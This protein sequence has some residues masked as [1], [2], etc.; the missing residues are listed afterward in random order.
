MYTEHINALVSAWNTG[1]LG[2]LDTFVATNTIRRAPASLFSDAHSLA[3]LKKVITDFR[4]TF[5]DTRVTIDEVFFLEGRSFSKWTFTG[6]NT[7]PGTH[8]T[9][10][11][12]VKVS[13]ASFARYQ[14]GK[15]IE[16]LVYFDALEFLSQL[17]LVETPKLAA[18]G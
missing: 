18:A 6:T 1:N 14:E 2:G 12:A 13:G 16:E 15:Q 4:T 3:E 9:T 11:K 17:G 5:P 8:P 10:G 7:G